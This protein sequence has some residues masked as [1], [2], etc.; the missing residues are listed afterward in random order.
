MSAALWR[1]GAETEVTGDEN[2]P[3][4]RRVK[5]PCGFSRL[6][7]ILERSA[8][9]QFA[10]FQR[11][12]VMSSFVFS[13]TAVST[14]HGPEEKIETTESPLA[15]SRDTKPLIYGLFQKGRILAQDGAV[16][17]DAAVEATSKVTATARVVGLRISRNIM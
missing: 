8:G 17:E 7:Q 11:P 12:E 15:G 6:V 3:V 14:R 9:Q 13:D 1:R 5:P 10:P 2:H 16:S 4:A